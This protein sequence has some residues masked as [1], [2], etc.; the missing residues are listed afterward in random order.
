MVFNY[1]FYIAS[2]VILFVLLLYQLSIPRVDRFAN[3]V[4]EIFIVISLIACILDVVSGAVLMRNFPENEELNYA[5]QILSCS[6]LHLI[7]PFYYF[8]MRVLARDLKHVPL[9]ILPWFIPAF[10]EQISI[11]TTAWSRL[12]FSYDAVN[13]YQRG[14]GM[15]IIILI[16]LFY[17]IAA[18]VEVFVFGKKL[19]TRYKVSTSI[20]FC[21]TIICLAVQLLIP[22]YVLLGAAVTINCLLMQL[23]LQNPK[24]VQEAK[25][26]EEIARIAAEQANEAKSNFLANMS[27]EIRTP[28]NA[29]CGMAEVLGKSDLSPLEQDYVRTI[30]QAS[31]SLLSIINDVLDFSKIDAGR[32]ELDVKNYYFEELITGVKEIIAARLQDKK[33]R[34]EINMGEVIPEELQGDQ[35]K[36]HQILINIL[37]NAVKFTE[38]GSI[39]M[40]VSFEPLHDN[41]ARIIFLI[42][43]TGIG[44]REEDMKKLFNR[45]TQVDEKYTR[46]AQGTGLGLV[47]SKSFAKLMEGDVTVTSE[48]GV[49]SCFRIEVVQKVISYY[50]MASLEMLQHYQAYIFEND[51]EERWYLTRILSQ[52]GISS[53]FLYNERQLFDLCERGIAKDDKYDTV[54][55]YN[56]EKFH[57]IVK[58]FDIPFRS[59]ALIEY[60]TVVRE[61]TFNDL[62]LR[63]PFELFRVI[64]VLE[65]KS[66][67]KLEPKDEE[68]EIQLKDAR[69]AVVDDN[70]VN[71]RVAI[72]LLREFGA[73][74]EAFGSGA[75]FLKASEKG[76]EYDIIFM[77]HMM[78]EMDGVETTRRFRQLEGEYFANVPIIALTA[79][80]I[81]GVE[82]DYMAAGMNDWLF[83]PVNIKQ[84]REKFLKFLPEDKI[85][86][87]EGGSK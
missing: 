87:V 46:K 30:Q 62:Y 82:K 83:K 40:D 21:V 17:M 69:V 77:D 50:E 23:T 49:G 13:G 4:Y 19:N 80:A 55:F 64:Q 58:Q 14:F 71:L 45:F 18:I 86:R 35:G 76:R 44:I 60:Y 74:P 81:D 32:Y 63:K 33:V 52:I 34:F 26:Q 25:E 47:L 72:S 51:P 79:N 67:K 39:T 29:I 70:K 10:L 78:P 38:E 1:D 2:I 7:P 24:M 53:V 12:V 11:W 85:I 20:F 66:E 61:Q 65:C 56:Y 37:G 36:I 15:I 22:K 84:F 6:S 68:G 16:A 5:V 42:T 8:Y 27:H 43:D 9:K 31:Q 57:D 75:G 48:Y 28:M 59:V 3:R 73:N 54:L 41:K